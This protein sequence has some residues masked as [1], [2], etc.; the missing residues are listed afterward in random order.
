MPNDFTNLSFQ[1]DIAGADKKIAGLMRSMGILERSAESVAGNIS[2]LFSSIKTTDFKITAARDI[3]IANTQIKKMRVEMDNAKKVSREVGDELKK[4]TDAE[5][6]KKQ[7]QAIYDVCKS[8]AEMIT[9]I[10]SL[11]KGG[12]FGSDSL[13]HLINTSDMT[14]QMTSVYEMVKA[15]KNAEKELSSSGNKKNKL[16][17]DY[18]GIQKANM[19]SLFNDKELEKAYGGGKGVVTLSEDLAAVN[20]SVVKLNMSLPAVLANL[21]QIGD[22]RISFTNVNGLAET[23]GR[24]SDIGNSDGV[25]KFMDTV[26][27]LS[28]LR[29]ANPAGDKD[30]SSEKSKEIVSQQDAINKHLESLRNKL[31]EPENQI[32]L[33]VKFDIGENAI[34][35]LAVQAILA[36]PKVED[37]LKAVNVSIKLPIS[38]DEKAIDTNGV[39]DKVK[40]LQETINGVISSSQ[41][42]KATQVTM[43]PFVPTPPSKT[44][45]EEVVRDVRAKLKDF[46]IRLPAFVASGPSKESLATVLSE[47]RKNINE[48]ALRITNIALV[49]PTKAS[50][51]TLVDGIHG[52]INANPPVMNV[53]GIAKPE[54]MKNEII[55]ITNELKK[56]S[57]AA[58]IPGVPNDVMKSLESYGK[59]LRSIATALQTI[60]NLRIATKMVNNE[61]TKAV[62]NAATEQEKASKKKIEDINKE[63]EAIV[64]QEKEAN[65]K[66]KIEARAQVDAL[67]GVKELRKTQDERAE[68]IADGV[69]K[70]QVA[71]EKQKKISEKSISSIDVYTKSMADFKK[72]LVDIKSPV[73]DTGNAIQQIK[74]NPNN[75]VDPLKEL[76]AELKMT[77]SAALNLARSMGMYVGGRS[78]INFFSE[79]TR[80]ANAFGIELRKIQSLESSYTFD[81]LSKGLMEIDSRFGNVIHNATTLYWAFSSGVRG[82]EKEL[83]DFTETM[84]K[85]AITISADV[86]PTMDA[87][88][89]LMNAY[90]LSARDAKEVGDLMFQIVKE[91][92][93]S[94]TELSSSLGHVVATAAS[95]GVS[96]DELGASIATLTRSIRTSRSLTYLNNILGKMINPTDQVRQAAE[97]L[98]VDFSMTA[99]RAKGF[100][101]VMRELQ[102]ATGGNAE[103]IAQLFPDLRGQR[104][105]ITLLSTQFGDFEDQL[106]KFKNKEGSMESAL[107]AISDTPEAQLRSLKNTMTMIAIEAGRTANSFMTLGGAVE[108]VLGWFNSMSADNKALAG[109]MAAS[110][111]AMLGM[112]IAQKAYTA[113]QYASAQ[114]SIQNNMLE[115]ESAKVKVQAAEANRK[116]ALELKQLELAQ[117]QVNI[118]NKESAN[119]TL[120]ALRGDLEAIKLQEQKIKGLQAEFK[121]Q[122]DI[123]NLANK[124]VFEAKTL[125][126]ARKEQ[127]TSGLKSILASTKFSK[128]N[129]DSKMDSDMFA[130]LDRQLALMTKDAIER[131]RKMKV[132]VSEE[133]NNLIK[134]AAY[135]QTQ[136]LDM[137]ALGLPDNAP[138]IAESL[139]LAKS[140]RQQA[141]AQKEMIGV[142][143][144]AIIYANRYKQAIVALQ[145]QELKAAD[146]T[147]TRATVSK[148]F[149]RILTS[150]IAIQSAANESEKKTLQVQMQ[151]VDMSRA[152]EL[153]EKKISLEQSALSVQ[154]EKTN[155]NLK[156][157]NELNSS[158]IA[159]MK[160][161]EAVRKAAINEL[162]RLNVAEETST[163]NMLANADANVRSTSAISGRKG[164]IAAQTVAREIDN[165]ALY[166]NNGLEKANAKE[167]QAIDAISI[168]GKTEVA[169]ATKQI[170]AAI[171]QEIKLEKE[172]L[173][174]RTVSYEMMMKQKNKELLLTQ[175]QTDLQKQQNQMSI[176]EVGR[177]MGGKQG[178]GLEMRDVG[179]Y[180]SMLAGRGL[181]AAFGP[182]AAMMSMLPMQKM[183]NTS[184]QMIG[185]TAAAMNNLTGSMKLMQ[186]TGLVPAAMS[187]NKLTKGLL[188]NT[189]A[190]LYSAKA[191]RNL[192]TS[193]MASFAVIAP[194]TVAITALAVAIGYL[195]FQTKKGGPMANVAEWMYGVKDKEEEQASINSIVDI[196]RERKEKAE[197][198]IQQ[199]KQI[200]WAS[201]SEVTFANERLLSLKNA[202]ASAEEIVKAQKRLAAANAEYAREIGRQKDTESFVQKALSEERKITAAE[203]AVQRAK[204]ALEDAKKSANDARAAAWAPS[205]ASKIIDERERRINL[206]N[207]ALIVA[208]QKLEEAKQSATAL[209]NVRKLSFENEAKS[210]QNRINFDKE[211]IFINMRTASEQKAIYAKRLKVNLETLKNAE[212]NFNLEKLMN[213]EFTA[214]KNLKDVE[215]K[216][217]KRMYE[218]QWEKLKAEKDELQKIYDA[219]KKARE[220]LPSKL[221]DI[222]KNYF[223]S[224]NELM[225]SIPKELQEIIQKNNENADY[226]SIFTGEGERLSAAKKNLEAARK[227]ETDVINSFPELREKFDTEEEALA[228]HN[229]AMKDARTKRMEME[230]EFNSQLTRLA[231]MVGR[232]NESITQR[233]GELT[234]SR[235]ERAFENPELR[236]GKAGIAAITGRGG[237][238]LA[239]I[240]N[241]WNKTISKE[242]VGYANAYQEELAKNKFA[243]NDTQIAAN[244]QA[245]YDAL[246]KLDALRGQ[247]IDNIKRLA[248]AEKTA[249]KEA[250]DLAI[251]LNNAF[252]VT[253]QQAVRANSMDAVRLMSRS[254]SAPMQPTIENTA[255]ERLIQMQEKRDADMATKLHELQ[256]VIGKVN[257]RAAAAGR[258]VLNGSAAIN[259]AATKFERG[260]NTF[261]NSL[262]NMPK[263]KI[264]VTKV[265]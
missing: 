252:K 167:T 206:A 81:N 138:A 55:G 35:G 97:K 76:R 52:M 260:T 126:I 130:T 179:M 180:G 155:I 39:N 33:V 66:R 263:F 183:W 102:A 28:S 242:A 3:E 25:K 57:E 174:L 135:H 243:I 136:A 88:T 89:S 26:N 100:T 42:I 19:P 131:E 187:S 146:A 140:F 229:S 142:K 161:K 221:I 232:T 129:V 256:D 182:G 9:Q 32:P 228:A 247:S 175:K 226:M 74:L 261:D 223:S 224:V 239:V 123:N 105:A 195:L 38:I 125:E 225:S 115:L 201:K 111:A 69:A 253:S 27:A 118:A 255:Q 165:R 13:V 101:Q 11:K 173:K 193:R 254:F 106:E 134:N 4:G 2:S 99:V 56:L 48:H 103:A 245:A 219:A 132:Q 80:K 104:A 194:T 192:A 96:I 137:K 12:S 15:V 54:E 93:A 250:Y 215:E 60:Q 177:Q 31:S 176:F 246:M 121:I 64:R 197:D 63:A 199:S 77:D 172:K 168:K 148:A 214:E 139:A 95:M 47:T 43:P 58:K 65:E 141:M 264:E 50:V 37:K 49:Q 189:F 203:D 114:A 200:L 149:E 122:N 133:T 24:F 234:K 110:G 23:F 73:L 46:S 154:D 124:S 84:A 40:G 1:I 91:G 41:G 212:S 22:N 237:N 147:N 222:Y 94:G 160:A 181:A 107:G 7:R 178:G 205:G 112:L 75:L 29:I 90:G 17:F 150:Q 6:F 5:G 18:S 127:I 85:T 204:N 152:R 128:D 14:M 163:K 171:G 151:G 190:T 153:L 108:P 79:A 166:L 235:F 213:N 67:D 262:K 72:S 169:N 218:D 156:I 117:L 244:T 231:E 51:K 188:L 186:V 202:G 86:I 233:M 92:K 248:D 143:G 207:E 216:L 251:Q 20:D 30:V 116:Q 44:K 71:I 98:G 8:L 184:K 87:A 162:Q 10:D 191:E 217:K 159:G 68:I 120:A 82:T 21:E 83:V 257:E 238:P 158:G 59:E 196:Y 157:Q 170:S 119:K 210:M 259:S 164:A 113:A 62:S 227:S 109:R 241:E 36:M 185:A 45:I 240:V 53:V 258:D 236:F 209:E 211:S 198:L 220:D 208:T 78:V 34:N 265:Y 230:K 249:N 70:Q 61:E 144:N 16:D 145:L